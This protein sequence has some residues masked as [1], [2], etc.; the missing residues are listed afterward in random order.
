MYI[1]MAY[2]SQES[3]Y[4]IRTVHTSEL[5]ACMEGKGQPLSL[6]GQLS[7]KEL[8]PVS[9]LVGGALSDSVESTNVHKGGGG[10]RE[11]C[12][13]DTHRNDNCGLVYE[14]DDMQ[15]G[16]CRVHDSEVAWSISA[17]RTRRSPSWPH[18]NS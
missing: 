18:R 4:Y 9:E 2:F 7:S 3:T 5:A 6:L 8:V 12:T 13:A 14:D 15:K 10:S 17:F 11:D 16:E 1:G